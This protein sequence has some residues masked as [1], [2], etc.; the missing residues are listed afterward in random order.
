MGRDVE[1]MVR[2][3]AEEAV[4]LVKKQ[5]SGRHG[6]DAEEAAVQKIAE[7]MWPAKKKET[8]SPMEIILGKRRRRQVFQM[9]GKGR[10]ERICLPV[11]GA[12]NWTT[13]K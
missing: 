12:A 5:E 1:S 10:E 3:L 4:R 13:A 2:D 7:I 8:R 6:K 11:S 9:K